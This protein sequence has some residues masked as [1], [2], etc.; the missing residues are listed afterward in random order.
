MFSFKH[1]DDRNRLKF[2]LN[3]VIPTKKKKEKN[4]I[5]DIPYPIILS[6]PHYLM[7]ISICLI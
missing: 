5:Y 3:E 7:Q 1:D 2:F 6:M 4:C